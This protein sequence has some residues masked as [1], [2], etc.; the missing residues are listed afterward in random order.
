MS[1]FLDPL[2]AQQQALVD[3]VW[4][5]FAKTN[6]FPNYQWV[7]YMMRR[8][9]YNAAE[10]IN[11]MPAVGIPDKLGRYSTI[12]VATIGGAVQLDDEVRLTMA[13]L[14]HV[15]S[16]AATKVIKGVLEYARA[17]S[18]AQDQ[19]ADHPF[20]GYSPQLFLRKSLRSKRE[21]FLDAVGTVAE[22][23]WVI[24]R[25]GKAGAQGE[26]WLGRL[27][28]VSE[29]NFT[30]IE[31]YLGA[32]IA[33]C[34]EPRP[35]TPV[36]A[37]QKALSLAIT[38]FDIT[39]ELV[40]GTP[41]V[42][43][44]PISRTV[45]FGMDATSLSDLQAAISAVGEIVAGLRVPG[46]TPSHP[47]GRLL[48]H[49]TAQLPKLQS[50]P[51]S[52]AIVTDAIA[53]LDAAREIRNSGVHSKPAPQLFAAYDRLGLPL[54]IVEPAAAWNT[55]RANLTLAFTALQLEIHAAR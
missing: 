50:N 1:T 34:P 23:E 21:P 17:L 22:H 8:M 38:N 19:I 28:L 13:G 29:A 33:A 14:Y 10:A 7:E 25:I 37:D 43:L 35:S 42:T 9:G 53:V 49:L 39:C 27:A 11:T 46:K 20:G 3:L 16:P 18:K 41:M 31:E 48:N 45:W 32:V 5:Q 36:Y 40:L 2:D 24:M 12:W 47:T 26:D 30:T 55:I 4:P 54:S 6:R 51:A 52:V 44:P 15:N